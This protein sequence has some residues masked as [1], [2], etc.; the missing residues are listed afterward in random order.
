MGT[1]FMGT[2]F[3]GIKFLRDQLS[4]GQ[5]I[6]RGQYDNIECTVDLRALYRPVVWMK[7]Y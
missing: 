3:M 7:E 2:K 5:K 4:V 6:V 1:K